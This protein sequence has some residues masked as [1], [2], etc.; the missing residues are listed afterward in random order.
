M[1]S[2]AGRG[3]HSPSDSPTGGIYPASAPGEQLT[4]PP[5]SPRQAVVAVLVVSVV[6]HSAQVGA[7]AGGNE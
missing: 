1:T 7:L 6:V 2:R 3:A 5:P 4:A